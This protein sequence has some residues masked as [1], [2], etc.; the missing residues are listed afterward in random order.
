MKCAGRNK[1]D[2]IGFHRAIFGRNRCPFDKGQKIALHAFS[3]YVRPAAVRPR[4]DLVNLI[5]KDNAFLFSK[6]QR[7]GLHGFLVE[8][9]IG[10]FGDQDGCGGGNLKPGCFFAPPHG[11]RQHVTEIEILAWLA[12]DFDDA[13]GVRGLADFEL[14][15]LV[16]QLSVAQFFAE[17]V[18]RCGS[19][20]GA[21]QRV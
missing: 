7:F 1:Q 13:N 4:R 18:A 19:R 14:D 2:I 15:F 20:I 10:F 12:G 17:T 21:H 16:I 6:V 11:L 5:D 3:R 9:F 8:Q